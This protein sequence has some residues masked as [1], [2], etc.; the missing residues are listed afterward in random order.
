MS[1]SS[2]INPFS[3]KATTIIENMSV[4]DVNLNANVN[5]NLVVNVNKQRPKP[6]QIQS[7]IT[8]KHQLIIKETSDKIVELGI[9]IG[10]FSNPQKGYSKVRGSLN[11]ILGITTIKECPDE[12]FSQGCNYLSRWLYAF[13]T[14]NRVITNPPDWWRDYLLNGIHIHTS[15]NGVEEE[16]Y[17]EFLKYKY[18]VTSSTELDNKKLAELFNYSKTGKFDAS[19]QRNPRDFEMRINAFSIYLDEKEQEGNFNRMNIRETRA[20]VLSELQQRDRSLFS[21]SVSTFDTFL[22]KAKKMISFNFKSGSRPSK[23]Y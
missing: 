4:G 14:N 6:I 21:I 11:K 19:R 8:Q 12:L 18:F 3:E 1:D 15:T 5:G 7:P 10:E 13:L 17:R 20:K 2:N 22:K 9:I 23:T 16:K